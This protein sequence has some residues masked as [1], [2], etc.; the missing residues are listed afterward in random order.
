[1]DQTQLPLEQESRLRLIG[2]VERLQIL[3]ADGKPMGHRQWR[4]VRELCRQIEFCGGSGSNWARVSTLAARMGVE[5]RTVQRARRAAEHWGLLSV[6]ER[7]G[8]CGQ[9]TNQWSVNFDRLFAAVRRQLAL[10]SG[11][12]RPQLHGTQPVRDQLSPPGDKLSP[13]ENTLQIPKKT[14][15]HTVVGEDDHFWT[16][17]EGDRAIAI[18]CVLVSKLRT[19]PTVANRQWIAKAAALVVLGRLREADLASATEGARQNAT[20]A[21]YGHLWATLSDL[22]KHRGRSLGGLLGRLRTP[23]HFWKRVEYESRAPVYCEA[24]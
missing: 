20:S 8:A 12:N 21:P 23:E 24:D 4:T 2:Q 10:K 19:P 3:D 5:K 16:S 22:T 1:M 17:G 7:W 15:D 9:R 6:T 18:A 11:K 13:L 14:R